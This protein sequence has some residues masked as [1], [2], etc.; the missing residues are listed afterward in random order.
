[1]KRVRRTFVVGCGVVL[2]MAFVGGCGSSMGSRLEGWFVPVHNTLQTLGFAQVGALHDGSL[3]E[4]ASQIISLQL[5]GGA[6][7]TIVGMGGA[8]V[9]DLELSLADPGG[10][11]MGADTAAGRQAV[12]RAC[13]QETG[14]Y[15]LT[16]RMGSGAGDF[17]V[18]MWSFAGMGGVPGGMPGGE[19]TSMPA[20][21]GPRGS[22]QEPLA[23]EVGGTISGGTSG[24]A[25]Q[26]TSCASG[27]PAA[28]YAVTVEETSY[29]T[30]A[31]TSP[32]DGALALLSACGDASSEIACNDDAGDANHS[33]ISA[34]LQPGTY[35]LIVTGYN[36]QHG[37]F[38]L[39]VTS[40]STAE[41]QA[42]CSD[43]PLLVSGAMVRGTTAGSPG[44]FEAS[45]A[46][47]ATSP[48]ALY[49]LVLE[50]PAR[51]RIALETPNHDG[52]LHL[53][54]TCFD[55][56][57]ELACNDDQGNSN[58]S[59]ISKSLPAGTY[60][61]IVDGYSSNNS[62][63]FT[64]TATVTSFGGAAGVGDTCEDAERIADGASVRG[65]T[66][67][68][69]GNYTGSC[70]GNSGT[71]DRVYRFKVRSESRVRASLP[72]SDFNGAIYIQRRCGDLSTEVTC[73]TPDIDAVVPPGDYFLIVDGQGEDDFGEYVLSFGLQSSAELRAMCR[74]APLLRPDTPVNGTTSGF[75][76]FSATCG[77]DARGPENIYRLE[78]ARAGRARILVES[79]YDAVLHIRS[80]CIRPESEVACNDDHG[81]RDKAMVDMTLAAGTYFVFVD[82]YENG[83]G[84]DYKVTLWL[85]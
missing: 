60:F 10:T 54:S 35:F 8:G 79:A 23:L 61:V 68:A 71:P 15:A 2:L 12:V 82:T 59:L 80:D 70:S 52:A 22:C 45:C 66:V 17:T 25:P 65:N 13:A 42:M 37:A 51:V 21:P 11:L 50:E 14:S 34:V 5:P 67:A 20:P 85:E 24:G 27:A 78:M 30:F 63:P 77:K 1:M 6:C 16:V 26:M 39:A 75:G 76:Q 64:L 9:N 18:A 36:G 31:M 69:S 55:Q 62:G 46:S 83:T 41:L 32:Y 48:D 72:V 29:Y 84:G 3:K 28:I 81:E 7:Y 56:A 49:R 4:H 47:S 19:T 38:Q 58:H 43:A 73:G 53:R 33:R 74:E 57:T 44:R 40:Q